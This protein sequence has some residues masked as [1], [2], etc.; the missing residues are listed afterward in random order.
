MTEVVGTGL[1]PEGVGQGKL[2][3]DL[4]GPPTRT[5][6]TRFSDAYGYQ[7][8]HGS[9]LPAKRGDHHLGVHDHVCG[10]HLLNVNISLCASLVDKRLKQVY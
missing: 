9:R 5:E 3:L 4:T 2:R 10:M 6:R 1:R 8:L 7:V